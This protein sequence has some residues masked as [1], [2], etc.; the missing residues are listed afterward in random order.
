MKIKILFLSFIC[1]MSASAL[2]KPDWTQINKSFL[3]VSEFGAVGDGATDDTIAIRVAIAAACAGNTELQFRQGKSYLVTDRINLASGTSLVATHN[4]SINGN[5]A[6]ILFG[7]S[8]TTASSARMLM[9]PLGVVNIT[10]LKFQGFF[11]SLGSTAPYHD[12]GYAT[13]FPGYTYIW[14]IS[15][16]GEHKFLETTAVKTSGNVTIT[17]CSFKEIFGMACDLSAT[18]PIKIEFRNCEFIRSARQDLN[19]TQYGQG[20]TI[21]S[22]CLVEDTAMLPDNFYIDGVPTT[23]TGSTCNLQGSYGISANGGKFVATNNVVRN[24]NSTAITYSGDTN[25]VGDSCLMT[26]NSV[27]CNNSHA[28]ST[29]PTGALWS[30]ASPN[31]VISDNV[32]DIILRDT[33]E[34]HSYTTAIHAFILSGGRATIQGNSI[35]CNNFTENGIRLSLTTNAL[36]TIQGNSIYL[37]ATYSIRMDN[38]TD[39]GT[40]KSIHIANNTS[41]KGAFVR[42]AGLVTFDN[43]DFSPSASNTNTI[44]TGCYVLGDYPDPIYFGPLGFSVAT[45]LD[46]GIE[47]TSGYVAEVTLSGCTDF[48]PIGGL[49]MWRGWVW[50]NNSASGTNVMTTDG[51]ASYSLSL[52]ASSVLNIYNDCATTTFWMGYVKI[53][54][55]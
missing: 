18:G 10:N 13:T 4:L 24:Y 1:A 7:N 54:P 33:T 20:T 15:I 55:W 11:L 26:G 2:T 44:G 41:E 6:T 40:A 53:S 3:D 42:K 9:F 17:N 25:P 43:N 16:T 49:G 30:E 35:F 8:A 48:G 38:Y 19:I 27:T 37:P 31:T 34:V 32:V 47:L 51:T 23:F 52:N 12:V 28:R 46:T 36:A 22:G 21:F 50:K 29:N 5:G 14:P 39:G 45:T